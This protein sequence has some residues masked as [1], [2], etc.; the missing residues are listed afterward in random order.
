[1]IVTAIE[2]IYFQLYCRNDQPHITQ[3]EG[4]S[5]CSSSSTS[6]GYFDFESL[7]SPMNHTQSLEIYHCVDSSILASDNGRDEGRDGNLLLQMLFAKYCNDQARCREVTL[8]S[9]NS[10][11]VQYLLQSRWKN[12]AKLL[13]LKIKFCCAINNY[14]L[15]KIIN[16]VTAALPSDEPVFCHN[17]QCHEAPIACLTYSRNEEMQTNHTRENE[18]VVSIRPMSRNK[19]HRQDSSVEHH[20]VYRHFNDEFYR[21]CLMIRDHQ[22]PNDRCFYGVGYQIC[23]CF[24]Q[25][26][27]LRTLFSEAPEPIPDKA[28][29]LSSQIFKIKIDTKIRTR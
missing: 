23:C 14:L 19:K 11:F 29:K 1:M 25:G 22:G 21:Y 7:S 17:I 13:S 8:S 28:R 9:F 12:V 6:C 2:L 16:S 10:K 15:Q 3:T 27:I 18:E 24:L 26:R 20:C 4:V 5:L